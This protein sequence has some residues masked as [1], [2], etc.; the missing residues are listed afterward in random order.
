MI[1]DMK[2]AFRLLPYAYNFKANLFMGGGFALCGILLTVLFGADNIWGRYGGLLALTGGFFPVQMIYS[3]AV[4][5]EVMV[6]PLR[7]TLLTKTAVI[8]N[9]LIFVGVYLLI[10]LIR[11]I[12]CR[13][14]SILLLAACGELL[15]IA[16]VGMVVMLYG[17]MSLKYF[18]LPTIFFCSFYPMLNMIL[19]ENG[20]Q[21]GSITT[22][23]GQVTL[24]GL[25]ILLIGAVLS[26]G[27]T[28]LVYKKPICKMSQNASLRQ[29]M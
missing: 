24:V 2:K 19:G 4:S 17:A 13:G 27:I 28:I 16:V 29:Y 22:T 5:E 20:I 7:K 3:L 8:M 25:L 23:Y 14:N 21:L 11:G 10:A 18:W 12:Q 15:L 9:W 1:R 26:Y 6:S